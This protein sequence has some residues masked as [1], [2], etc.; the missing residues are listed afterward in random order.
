M[1]V[2]FFALIALFLLIGAASAQTSVAASG[3]YETVTWQMLNALRREGVQVR[4]PNCRN[5]PCEMGPIPEDMTVEQFEAVDQLDINGRTFHRFPSFV[6][7]MQNLK[8]LDIRG[9]SSEGLNNAGLERL[10]RLEVFIASCPALINV[11][12]ELSAISTLRAVYCDGQQRG[13]PASGSIQALGAII[14]SDALANRLQEIDT[15]F[16]L[17]ETAGTLGSCSGLIEYHDFPNLRVLRVAGELHPRYADI[18]SLPSLVSFS[19]P[20]CHTNNVIRDRMQ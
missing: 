11:V 4:D 17:D 9:V 7:S 12:R 14:A 8:F 6:F 5:R 3:A 15:L 16:G 18:F 2:L 1:K 13:S 20:I 10:M 19:G